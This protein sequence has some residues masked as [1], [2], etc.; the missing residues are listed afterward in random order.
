M[1]SNAHKIIKISLTLLLTLFLFNTQIIYAKDSPSVRMI[2]NEYHKIN[3]D[4]GK[5]K[6]VKKPLE[7]YSAEGA[8]LKAYFQHQQIKKMQI[9]F[10]GETGRAVEEYYFKEGH[11][12]FFYRVETHTDK[13]YSQGGKP[14][15]KEETRIYLFKGKLIHWLGDNNRPIKYDEA[16]YLAKQKELLK[17]VHEFL[18]AAAKK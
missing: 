17:N 18:T 5:Y 13:P 9:I 14:V 10:Y 7:G 16:K 11:L 8:T 6:L 4:L 15:S 2:R 1:L 3:D 12:I